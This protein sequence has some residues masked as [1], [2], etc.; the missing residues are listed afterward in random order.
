M[1]VLQLKYDFFLLTNLGSRPFWHPD[2]RIHSPFPNLVILHL[3]QTTYSLSSISHGTVFAIYLLGMFFPWVTSMG[4]LTGGIAST[5]VVSWISFGTQVA[6]SR[7]QITFPT[8]PF[9]VAGCL[10]VTTSALNTTILAEIP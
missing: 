4:A 3:P 10:N 9:S 2:H 8:K 6:I 5:A 7:Q 1:K